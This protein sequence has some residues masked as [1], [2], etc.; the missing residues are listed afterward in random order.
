MAGWQIGMIVDWQDGWAQW[1]IGLIGS[2][3]NRHQEIGLIADR[4]DS[5]AEG[6]L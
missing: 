1:L 6:F 5:D 2:M 3:V 4:L